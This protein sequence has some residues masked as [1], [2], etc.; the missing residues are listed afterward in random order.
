MNS[1]FFKTLIALIS[2]LLTTNAYSQTS[3]NKPK[4]NISVGYLYSK[5]D[6]PRSYDPTVYYDYKTEAGNGYSVSA[7]VDF[8]IDNFAISLGSSFSSMRNFLM[9]SRP[10]NPDEGLW[11]Y[12][13]ELKMDYLNLSIVLKY[14]PLGWL[15]FQSGFRFSFPLNNQIRTL[16][17]E[18]VKPNI[19]VPADYPLKVWEQYESYDAMDINLP[20]G[21]TFGLE[22][23]PFIAFNYYLRLVNMTEVEES[24]YLTWGGHRRNTFELSVGW[25][26]DFEKKE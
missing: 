19:S 15:S 9:F 14:Y 3:K 5:L 2:V 4:L 10:P 13:E 12:K 11:K 18:A 25:K 26:F 20:V 1:S 6:E 16:E 7:S 21:V 8:P 22:R 17:V 23:G 24:P